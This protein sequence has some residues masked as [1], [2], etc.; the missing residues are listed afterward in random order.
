MLTL[1]LIS[2]RPVQGVEYGM[3]SLKEFKSWLAGLESIGDLKAY[4]DM[5]VSVCWRQGSDRR[6]AV[7]EA[8]AEAGV[9]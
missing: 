6:M 7:Y 2:A 9:T 3:H 8:I 1:F 5:R 4:E